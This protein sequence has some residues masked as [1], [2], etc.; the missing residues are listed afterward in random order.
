MEYRATT[1]AGC[2]ARTDGGV[3]AVTGNIDDGEACLTALSRWLDR[4]AREQLLPM[5]DEVSA[6]VGLAYAGARV[7]NV[8]SR[9]GSCS[10]REDDLAQP[11]PRVPARRISCVRSCCTSSRTRS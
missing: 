11:Q 10:A 8:R 1:A 4:T 6:E 7:R 2:R 5:L 9:W 3:I